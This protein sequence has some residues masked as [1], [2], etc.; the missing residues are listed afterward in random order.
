MCVGL[1]WPRFA[2]DLQINVRTGFGLP[3]FPCQNEYYV[4]KPLEY[5]EAKAP[6]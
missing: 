5:P 6:R 3:N 4:P 2:Q 1:R